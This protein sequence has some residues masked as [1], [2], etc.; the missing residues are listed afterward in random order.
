MAEM[1][2]VVPAAGGRV[3]QP[4]RQDRVMPEEGAWVPLDAHYSRLLATGDV[5]RGEPPKEK[6]T[7][8]KSSSGRDA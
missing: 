6:S 5:S 3:R 1:I 2:Y 7:S 4:E 8:S